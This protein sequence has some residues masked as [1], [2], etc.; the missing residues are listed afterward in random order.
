MLIFNILGPGEPTRLHTLEVF[1]D[2]VTRFQ[3]LTAW[4]LAG[5]HTDK[6]GFEHVW[7]IWYIQW[8]SRPDAYSF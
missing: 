1:L 7:E 4:G 3:V 6:I 2:R 5:V 8:L